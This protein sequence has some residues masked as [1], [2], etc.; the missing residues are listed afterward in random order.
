MTTRPNAGGMPGRSIRR[1]AISILLAVC[2]CGLALA[3]S[4][5]NRAASSAMETPLSAPA[6]SVLASAPWPPE[7]RI[8]FE[9]LSLAQGLSQSV[10][11]SITQ[12]LTGYIWLATQDGLNRYDGSE[13]R[14]F[15]RNP[16]DPDSLSSNFINALLVD[17]LGRLWVGTNGG[18]LDL[19]DP[20]T[21]RFTHH[22]YVPGDPQSLNSN[23][24]NYLA[25]GSDGS[26]W[27]GT[28]QGLAH[29]DPGTGK[30]QRYQTDA[31][32]PGSLGG[33]SVSYLYVAPEGTLWVGSFDG[34]LSRLDPGADRFVRY[35]NA[36]KN[37]R[38]LGE[39]S[40]QCVAGDSEG[41]I[42]VG[43]GSAGLD[44]LD[45]TTGTFT[46]FLPD[47]GSPDALSNGAVFELLFDRRGTLWVGSNGGGL[48]RFDAERQTF[49]HLRPLTGDEQSLASD[50]IWSV[51]EDRAG[52]LWFGTFGA[53]VDRHDP[54]GAKFGLL[55]SDAEQPRGLN[56][57]QVWAILEDRQGILWIGTNGGGVNRFDRSRGTWSSY[58]AEPG[59]PQALQGNFILSLFEDSRNDL[60][61]GTFDG[62]VS[63]LDRTTQE[64]VTLPSPGFVFDFL[65]D[66][67]GVMWMATGG[68]L[69]RF[70]E[71]RDAFR[72]FTGTPEDPD[73][74]ADN[75]LLTMLED[76]RG[77]F[78]V[79]S[80]AGGLALFDRETGKVTRYQND[81]EDLSSLSDNGVLTLLEDSRGQLWVG[82]TAGLNRFDPEAGTFTH[83]LEKDGLPNDVV[84]GILED[85]QGQLWLSTNKGLSRFNP[86]AE[87]FRNYGTR[88]GLQGDEFNQGAF[89]K[90]RA[91]L[92]YFGG[93]EGLNV[94]DPERVADNPYLMPVVLTGFDLFNR[95]VKPGGDTPLPAPIDQLSSL[96]LSYRDDFFGFH[97]AGLHFSAPETHQY[98]YRMDGLDREW[99]Y[100]GS[101]RI[102]T[103]TNVLPG[104]YTFH[105]R[106]ANRDGVWNDAG[107]SL[108]VVVTP[109]FWQTWWFRIL[110][111]LL[112]VGGT[113][114]GVAWRVRSIQ[115]L[116]RRLEEQVAERTQELR[117]ALDQLRRSKDAAEAANRAKSVFLANM[118]HEFRTPLNA[119]LGFSQ[120]M[121]RPSAAAQP[122]VE[123]LSSDQRENLQVIVRSGEHLLGLINDV[124]EMSKIE[125]GRATLNEQGFDLHRML[126]GL[127]EMFAL[128]AG[129][130]G[131]GLSLERASDVPQ[132]V[133]A[134]EGKLRQILMN[135]L[136]NAVK[137]TA[138][139]GV[140][141]RAAQVTCAES[142]TAEPGCV[143]RFEVEDTGPGI[144]GEEQEALFRPFVQTAAG[145]RAQE[146]TGLGLA[147]SQQFARLMGGELDV[148]S[149][150]GRGSTFGLQVPVQPLDPGEMRTALPTRRVVAL[151]P[152]QPIYRVLV[153]DD[154]EVNR[155]L[156]VK[157]LAPL[158][159]EVRE[160]ADGLQ[161]IQTWEAWNPQV[162]LMDMRMPVMDGYEATRRIKATTRGQATVIVAVTAS[163]LE[164]ERAVILSEGCDA[165]MRKPFREDELFE[166]L[167]QHLGVRFVY[168]ETTER[169]ADGGPAG[170]E[171]P[172]VVPRLARLPAAL[173][174]QLERATVLGDLQRIESVVAQIREKDSGLADYLI[175]LSAR[176]EHDEILALVRAAGGPHAT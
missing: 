141:L 149:E 63:R 88:D 29:F 175:G 71:A 114:G 113:V 158:G 80:F 89:Y 154:K 161:A 31:S 171:R 145:Q 98:A 128:R 104:T 20:A 129:Q 64:F 147:I 140:V 119:I 37:P 96:T 59:N 160:A 73:T 111:A 36:P 93:I 126:D 18:G 122:G 131:I 69:A 28:D 24:V 25:E 9:H 30:S 136:G 143:L 48:H 138:Q 66:R 2:A 110:V 11:T 52:V 57:S 90:D 169:S 164:E 132:Y 163:A 74:F 14:V 166:T 151:E 125:A 120:L 34:G 99:N 92:M 124:L 6:A 121:L 78:W 85:P 32:D 109:P 94:F 86:E 162:I 157:S 51:F 39:N 135:L 115:A 44:R 153:V 117:E 155:K 152:G 167:V 58:Q 40:V 172:R 22:R 45:P 112:V 61:I 84:Y 50:A 19:F 137:F 148:R 67:D 68:G 168:A 173:L 43:L 12:D 102:A 54:M 5:P 41:R 95:P 150:L 100:V 146:G 70:N 107:V 62:G 139:G 83:Y 21:E 23:V 3:G 170:D 79:G 55:R 133:R 105:V 10:V 35:V 60:W 97:F 103:Y 75:G 144:P 26:L 87:T 13:L 49:A 53:G 8:R 176:F 130:K 106:G 47:P 127:E 42:W 16:E 7:P 116:N 38:S 27:V 33:T 72:V 118:S 77:H 134:D 56:N 174:A 4:P 123:S 165:Y 159:F 65:E 17:P 91:G 76:S 82:T 81:P 46:H 1:R 156:L 15:K 101:R 142:G 108:K